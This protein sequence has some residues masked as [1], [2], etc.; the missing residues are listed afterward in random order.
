MKF[1]G[2][3]RVRGFEQERLDDFLMLFYNTVHTINAKDYAK[4]Q[5]DAWAPQ[6]PDRDSWRKKLESSFVAAAF[7]EN[8]LLLGY[9]TLCG[10]S[11]FDLLYINK[12]YQR[13]GIA[14]ILSDA[15]EN[16]SKKRGAD[17]I[18]TE[19][20][21][22]AKPFFE[23]RGYRV[24]KEQRKPLRGEVFINYVM[25]KD[26]EEKK[27]Q[28]GENNIQYENY[29]NIFPISISDLSRTSLGSEFKT[30]I[31]RLE[32]SDEKNLK[33][34]QVIGGAGELLGAF[35]VREMS[36]GLCEIVVLI[37]KLWRGKGMGS[38][39]VRH[40]AEFA[41]EKG[42]S[43]VTVNFDLKCECLYRVFRGAGFKKSAENTMIFE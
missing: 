11:E 24:I 7:D 1:K 28:N 40:A 19:A 25:Q 6:M 29:Y 38:E 42:F 41:V 12:D 34:Y 16:E 31:R 20:S 33:Y 21:I 17:G 4:D 22:T 3:I 37:D 30:L 36:M 14:S 39:F 2:N 9:A 43:K 13:K 26:F 27:A 10:Y 35:C 5:L 8:D 32:S 23:H 15:V 18:F